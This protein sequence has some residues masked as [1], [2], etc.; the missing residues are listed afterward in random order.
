MHIVVPT[1][2]DQIFLVILSTPTVMSPGKWRISVSFPYAL[3]LTY[4]ISRTVHS[5]YCI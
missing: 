2:Y 4:S 1:P 3:L 5:L